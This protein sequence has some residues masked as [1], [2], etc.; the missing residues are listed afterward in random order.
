MKAT[1]DKI[2]KTLLKE[3]S[4]QREKDK[5]LRSAK[6]AMYGARKEN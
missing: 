6:E 4:E 3:A 1:K 5:L 2:R